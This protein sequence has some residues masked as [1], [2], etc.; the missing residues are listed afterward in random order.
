MRLLNWIINIFSKTIGSWHWPWVDKS[1]DLSDYFETEQRIRDLSNPFVVGLVKTYGHGSNFLIRVAQCF[2]KDSCKDVTHALAHIG[3]FN[4][5]K[6]R[7]V[8]AIGEGIRE[9]SLLQAIGQRDNVILKKPNPKYLNDKCCKHIIEYIKEVAKRDAV[10]NI[11]YDNA[12]NY[13]TITIEEIKDY[14]EN[15]VKLDCSET[16]MQAII[17]GLRMTGQ[18]NYIQM[19]KRAGKMTWTPSDILH[20]ELFIDF[21]D[22]REK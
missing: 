16:I 12:H 2:S 17:H 5:Y 9:V 7:V 8:E 15:N 1:F 3:V 14:S 4:G 21:Y 11:Q 6:H 13:E 10:I 18:R 20:S 22:S 19:K